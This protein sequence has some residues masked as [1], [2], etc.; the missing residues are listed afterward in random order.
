MRQSRIDGGEGTQRGRAA[1]AQGTTFPPAAS[2]G[3]ELPPGE[4]H[5]SPSRQQKPR[6]HLELAVNEI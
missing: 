2:L 3:C 1:P 6:G 4:T 5:R